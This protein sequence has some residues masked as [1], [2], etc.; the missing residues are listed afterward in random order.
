MKVDC[1]H[2]SQGYCCFKDSITTK[3]FCKNMCEHFSE[4]EVKILKISKEDLEEAIPGIAALKPILQQQVRLVNESK[5]QGDID[6]KQIGKH[7]DIAI[8]S[9]ITV[10]EY[11]NNSQK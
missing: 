6:A 4:G 9:M 3:D 1:K 5:K 7:F 11:M 10:L 8:N 2:Y